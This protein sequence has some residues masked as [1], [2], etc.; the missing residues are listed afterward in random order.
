MGPSV[1]TWRAMSPEAKER[2]LQEVNAAFSD[3][4]LLM[5]EGRRH[6]RAKSRA[7][8]MLDLHFKR[9]GR[10]IYVAEEMSV[11][12]P[13]E[14][15]FA[16]DVL[17]V[18]DVAEPEDDPRMAWVVADEGKG[19]DF[20]LEVLDRGD[21][22]KDLIDNV[23]RCARL[24]IVEYFVYDRGAQR[25][26]G[27]RLPSPEARKY[28]RIVPQGGWYPSKV[29]GLDLAIQDGSLRFFDGM[30][31]LFGSDDLIRRLT[32]MV[33]SLEAKAAEAE[34]RADE[35]L[36]GLR[37]AVLRTLEAR[38]LAVD[39]KAHERVMAC[40]EPAALQ[41]WLLRAL[42]AGSTAEAMAD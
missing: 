4:N 22:N 36:N 18:L 17:A 21:R 28:E 9:S 42:S 2:F 40:E 27:H 12:Y 11:V 15:S 6:K 14:P 8:D 33:D 25:V 38:G 26:H 37:T 39:E 20:V 23:E 7:A 35:A 10:V 30:A 19:I 5:T 3:P 31:E 24:G 41:R 34:A 1:E 29:L 13:G 16:P 32:G